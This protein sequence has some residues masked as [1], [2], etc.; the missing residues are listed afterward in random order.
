ML[1]QE[2][3]QRWLFDFQRAVIHEDP[4]AAKKLFHRNVIGL[5]YGRPRAD[6]IELLAFQWSEQWKNR[7]AFSFLMQ[8]TRVI[9]APGMFVVVTEWMVPSSILGGNPMLGRTTFVLANFEGKLLCVHLHNS[10]T[11]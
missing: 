7:K 1:G 3:V 4:E 5:E 8:D 2:D 6:S 9:P 11:P 10:L